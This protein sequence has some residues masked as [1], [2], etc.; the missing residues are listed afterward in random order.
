MSFVGSLGFDIFVYLAIALFLGLLSSKIT[1][2]LKLPNVTGYIVI[3][4]LVG[5]H[6]LKL[7]PLEVLNDLSIISEIALGFIAFSIGAEFKLSYLKKVGKSTFAI[8]IVA[9]LGAVVLV[10]IA[11]ILA[12]NDVAFSIVLGSIGAATAPAATLMVIRQYKAK[13]PVTDT[14]LPVVAIDDAAAVMIFGISVAIA[15]AI[16][17]PGNTSLLMTLLSPVIE[18]VGALLL[19]AVLGVALAY[20]IKQF[21][22]DGNRLAIVIGMIFLSIGGSNFLGLSALLT[23]MMMSAVF[24]NLYDRY[25]KIFLLVDKLTPPIFML[26]FFISGANLDLSILPSVGVVGIIYIV[27]RVVGKVGGSALGA[28]M[29]GAEPVVAKYLGYT[30]IPQAGVAIGLASVAMT[31][32]PDYGAQIQTVILSATV[33][34]ELTGPLITKIAL[35]KAGEIT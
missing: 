7:I 24:V 5:P 12:G 15:K 27:F 2:R 31:A 4:L 22:G 11:L 6:A 25:K 26:F 8:A 30:L 17:S 34:Y 1:A 3:G 21:K 14:L 18:I 9:A 32:L 35:T 23:C 19:G 28:K 33:I 29:S 16:N 10:D 20:L 13:G